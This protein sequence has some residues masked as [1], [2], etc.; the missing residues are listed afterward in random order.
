MKRS[1]EVKQKTFFI[2]FKEFSAAKNCL[3]PESVPLVTMIINA[4][5]LVVVDR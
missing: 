4:S 3:R 2:M 5:D 1:F